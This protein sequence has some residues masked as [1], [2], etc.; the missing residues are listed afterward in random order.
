[1]HFGF[2]LVVIFVVCLDYAKTAR[3]HASAVNSDWIEGRALQQSTKRRPETREETAGKRRRLNNGLLFDVG[4]ILG[5]FGDH[6]G[7][8]NA[9]KNRVKFW[10]RFWRPKGG[11]GRQILGRPGGMRR[12]SGEDNGGVREHPKT[13]GRRG[14]GQ[15]D[16]EGSLA[17]QAMHVSFGLV[18]GQQKK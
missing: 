18:V 1:M 4:S 2:I 10:M 12:A 7:S 11:G 3:P 6:F 13:P 15:G 8:Q 14:Q 5:G 17:G 16:L 9:F